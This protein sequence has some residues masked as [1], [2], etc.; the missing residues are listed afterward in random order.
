VQAKGLSSISS[1]S[2]SAIATICLRTCGSALAAVIVLNAAKTPAMATPT[3]T[4]KTINSTRV[5]PRLRLMNI[6][7]LRLDRD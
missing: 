6:A 5:T 4:M 3:S 2:D 7:G 1:M